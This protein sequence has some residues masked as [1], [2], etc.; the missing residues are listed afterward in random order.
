M[1]S[2]GQ[3]RRTEARAWL[4]PSP[5][6]FMLKSSSSKFWED[7]PPWDLMSVAPLPPRAGHQSAH[8]GVPSHLSLACCSPCLY[9][10]G[11]L[12]HETGGKLA[13]AFRAQVI[14]REVEEGQARQSV[15]GS[16]QLSGTA[17]PQPVP[18]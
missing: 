7:R 5:R 1:L 3:A 18:G 8:P 14:G 13:Q 15:Q 9:L 10:Q 4:Q 16:Q 12:S 17:I 6:G 11:G 2:A